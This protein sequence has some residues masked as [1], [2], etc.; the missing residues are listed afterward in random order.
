[1]TRKKG[2]YKDIVG[3]K[4]GKWTVLSFSHSVQKTEKRSTPYWN[5]ISDD[6]EECVKSSI[7]LH[8]LR[9][10]VPKPRVKKD[11]YIKYVSE[12]TEEELEKR[13]AYFRRY[14]ETHREQLRKAYK[15]HYEKSL[16]LEQKL[17]RWLRT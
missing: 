14:R 1:M 13:R 10:Y 17:K 16:T 12:L 6:G 4:Y 5:C 8:H 15:K 9:K 3:E 7:A 11:H 2:L